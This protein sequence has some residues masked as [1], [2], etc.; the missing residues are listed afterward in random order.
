MDKDL[1]NNVEKVSDMRGVL[2]NI[3]GN[4]EPDIPQEEAIR[5]YGEIKKKPGSSSSD[6]DGMDEAER[7]KIVKTELL[8]SLKRVEQIEKILYGKKEMKGNFKIDTKQKGGKQTSTGGK[9]VQENVKQQ[10]RD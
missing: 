9:S 7:L 8:E 10:E 3:F 5:K 4:E 1:G 6:D 2:G